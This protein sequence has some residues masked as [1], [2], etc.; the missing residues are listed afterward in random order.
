[1]AVA[2][3]AEGF[4]DGPQVAGASPGPARALSGWLGGRVRSWET[5]PPFAQGRGRKQQGEE[6][7]RVSAAASTEQPLGFGFVSKEEV[8]RL[9]SCP[10]NGEGPVGLQRAMDGSVGVGVLL[11]G[12]PRSKDLCVSKAPGLFWVA[13]WVWRLV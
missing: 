7:L 1:M 5:G 3:G 4:L 6:E 9:S 2:A 10:G 13:V 8:L 12:W 11:A